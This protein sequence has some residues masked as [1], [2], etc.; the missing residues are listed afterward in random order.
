MNRVQFFSGLKWGAWIM[1][2]EIN[3]YYWITPTL[4][5]EWGYQLV[6]DLTH[7]NTNPVPRTS[8][9][10]FTASKG[11]WNYT[12]FKVFIVFSIVYRFIFSKL[13]GFYRFTKSVWVGSRCGYHS[14]KCRAKVLWCFR[15]TSG[16]E[17]CSDA[18]GGLAWPA[19]T[20]LSRSEARKGL[21]VCS[22]PALRWLGPQPLDAEVLYKSIPKTRKETKHFCKT[23][24]LPVTFHA[25]KYSAYILFSF[26]ETQTECNW[27]GHQ[28]TLSVSLEEGDKWHI[29]QEPSRA[30]FSCLQL[31][32]TASWRKGAAPTSQSCW[33]ASAQFTCSK[34]RRWDAEE[35]TVVTMT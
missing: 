30:C 10:H 2:S 1:C 21:F 34:F 8:H 3:F 7:K 5:L 25:K 24:S 19:R 16:H 15:Q 27:S 12:T 23:H 32:S 13:S 11:G 26:S 18:Q 14:S 6:W 31:H 33:A 28:P 17:S 20:T 9:I 4:L 29:A 35:N 22:V